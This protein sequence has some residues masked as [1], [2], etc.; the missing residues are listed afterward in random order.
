MTL[1]DVCCNWL[2]TTQNHYQVHVRSPGY[3]RSVHSFRLAH[4]WGHADDFD[5]WLN[6]FNLCV[7]ILDRLVL[8]PPVHSFNFGVFTNLVVCHDL[9][10][11]TWKSHEGNEGNDIIFLMVISRYF[12]EWQKKPAW[13]LI[14]NSLLRLPMSRSHLLDRERR[15]KMMKTLVRKRVHL[16]HNVVYTLTSFCTNCLFLCRI[17][18][19][20]CC[21]ERK[22]DVK[23]V[24]SRP[25]IRGNKPIVLKHISICYPQTG[26][27][28]YL[29]SFI[30]EHI[31]ASLHKSKQWLS[32]QGACLFNSARWE[33]P[34]STAMSLTGNS[35]LQK[36]RKPTLWV[37]T[38]M[39][40]SQ[41][42]AG[43]WPGSSW[44]LSSSNAGFMRGGAG[45]ASL[46]R[47]ILSEVHPSSLGSVI[48]LKKVSMVMVVLCSSDCPSCC[49]RAD[50]TALQPHRASIREVSCTA[51]AA[52]D[53]WRTAHLLQVTV[54]TDAFTEE[55]FIILTFCLTY[56]STLNTFHY[57]QT[58]S[59]NQRSH[60][61]Q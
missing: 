41:Q 40:E 48:S 25:F 60:S 1:F 2:C 57:M 61:W 13:M 53:V 50:C 36:L 9:L 14:Q 20:K 18:F 4:F 43:G 39:L 45:G 3:L 30:L 22:R 42:S 12:C 35:D 17:F 11:I 24:F 21:Q 8:P 27:T 37:E 16:Q 33:S 7:T 5:W 52:M 59:T 6:L 49:V 15:D 38:A 51:F 32:V 46:L 19:F 56:A 54:L 44:G 23:K 26:Y 31:C 58:P 34:H 55:T 29:R 10:S 47:W 28:F